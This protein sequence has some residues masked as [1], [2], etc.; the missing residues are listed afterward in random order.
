MRGSVT[1]SDTPSIL[2][3]DLRGTFLNA[4]AA[5]VV[6]ARAYALAVSDRSPVTETVRLAIVA[7]EGEAEAVCGLLRSEGIRCAHRTTDLSADR[8][9]QF[10]GWR[11]VLVS[12]AD[13]AHARELLAATP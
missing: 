12:T 10:G 13:E 8:G 9:L 7:D 2:E 3:R 6:R 4:G 5:V 11:E 1:G